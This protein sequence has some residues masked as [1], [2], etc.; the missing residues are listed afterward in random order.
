MIKVNNINPRTMCKIC[1]KLTTRH[2]NDVF[3]LYWQI[4]HCTLLLFFHFW[5]WA[6]KC[7]L[8]TN[9]ILTN[10]QSKRD[11]KIDFCKY[12]EKGITPEPL[13][14]FTWIF[15]LVHQFYLGTFEVEMISFCGFRLHKN[16]PFLWCWSQ[17]LL[18]FS[19]EY[20]FIKLM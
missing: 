5:L 8:G 18:F 3:Y 1:S 9:L 4:S 15:T 17:T 11:H 16:D 19:D 7:R 20:K 6:S 14:A 13:T 2:H 12:R 10:L